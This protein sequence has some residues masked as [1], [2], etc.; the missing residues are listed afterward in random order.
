MFGWE[1]ARRSQVLLERG[2]HESLGLCDVGGLRV[3]Y[4]DG[5]GGEGGALTRH[6]KTMDGFVA[7]IWRVATWLRDHLD[8]HHETAALAKMAGVSERN[9]HRLFLKTLGETPQAHVH[10]LRLERAAAWLAYTQLPTIQAALN[11]VYESREGFT[12]AFHVHFGCTPR[13][14]RQRVRDMAAQ[15][16]ARCPG[17]LG[18]PYE[19][20]LPPLR[21][22]A[23]PHR[24]SA[25]GAATAWLKLGAWGARTGVLTPHAFAITVLHDDDGIVPSDFARTDAALALGPSQ[26]PPSGGGLPFVYELEGGRHVAIPYEGSFGA[27]ERAWDYVAFRWFPASGF[28]LRSTRMLMLH[29]PHD[30]PTTPQQ[31]VHLLLSRTL[32]CRLCIPIDSVPGRGIPPIHG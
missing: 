20:T 24:G 4:V 21:L 30:V 10:R 9:F 28:S 27:L 22:A 3:G 23:W 32:R 13:E 29:D 5:G 16:P 12:R 25:F 17:E 6:N 7:R 11:G 26:E 2:A 1:T 14:F 15:T 31:R 19:T 8:E 18:A